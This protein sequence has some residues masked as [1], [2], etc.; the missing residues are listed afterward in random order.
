MSIKNKIGI[1]T[2][3][4][5]LPFT[6][7]VLY[8]VPQTENKVINDIEI[9]HGLIKHKLW[10]T[11]DYCLMSKERYEQYHCDCKCH[12]LMKAPHYSTN[13]IESCEHC[14]EGYFGK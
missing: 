5:T 3:K 14:I 1:K 8:D 6:D 9:S 2:V 7:E 11:C 10:E 12:E 4:R 13:K